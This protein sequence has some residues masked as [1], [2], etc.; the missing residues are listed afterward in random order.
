MFNNSVFSFATMAFQSTLLA[1]ESQQVI[2]M[3]LTKFALG[4]DD[5]QQEAELMVNEKMHSLMEAGH[6]MMAAALGGKSDLGADKVM[7][8][9]RTKVSA[10]VR[11]LSAA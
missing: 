6:M 8:H 2:A 9:Y 10:N 3:R 1:I 7:A 5:V 4:G 11:R